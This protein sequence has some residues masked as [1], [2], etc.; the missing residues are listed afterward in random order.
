[1]RFFASLLSFIVLGCGLASAEAQLVIGTYN[2]RTRTLNDQTNDPATN[3]YWDI[4]SEAVMQ[5]IRDGAFDVLALNELND[6]VSIDGKSMMQDMRRAFP[7]PEYD[8]VTA[9]TVPYD[10]NS[11]LHAI[12]YKTAVVE[13]LEQGNF[14]HAPDINRC[15]SGQWGEGNQR[16]MSLWA[17]FR[18]KA[19][20]EIFYVM[21]THLHH[22]GDM[23]KN[24][25]SR[26][27]VDMMRRIAGG[28]PA[29]I[30]GDHN[31]AA[32]RKPFYD[33]HRAFFDDS[34]AVAE[35][36]DG[37]D[38]TSNT[39]ND[40]HVR[41]DYV[42]ARSAKILDYS[43]PKEKYGLDFYPSDHFP[44]RVVA[45]LEAPIETRLRYVSPE[46]ADG[47][48]GSI[49]APFNNIQDAIDASG[50]GDTLFIA[51]GTYAPAPTFKIERSLTLVGGYNDD[52]SAIEGV[53]ALTGD[54]NAQVLNIGK[55][56]A[57]E[58]SNFDISG[59]KT[60]TEPG[61]GIACHGPRLMLEN[62]SVHDNITNGTGAGV[63]A[64][65][66]LVAER[67]SFERNITTGNGGAVFCNDNGSTMPWAHSITECVFRGNKAMHGAAAYLKSTLWLNAH[68][69]TFSDNEASGNGIF[70][71]T[72]ARTAS[73]LTFFNNTFA[74]NR[75]AKG[76][77]IFTTRLQ[78]GDTPASVALANN[79]IVANT[80]T[81]QGDGF[82]GAAVNIGNAVNVYLNN[83]IIAANN[84]AAQQA[85]VYCDVPSGVTSSKY[86]VFSTATSVNHAIQS[87]D[88]RAGSYTQA[89][90]WLAQAFD[91]TATDAKL[92][93]QPTDNGGHTPTIRIVNPVYGTYNL[94]KL[95]SSR[96]V[97]T[98]IKADINGD[99]QVLKA[100][101]TSAVDQRGVERDMK[102]HASFGAYEYDP[103]DGITLPTVSPETDGVDEYFN[104]QGVKIS[105]P[106]LPGIYIHKN[107]SSASKT[108]IK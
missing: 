21:C 11:V 33:L 62:V 89:A 9:L 30:C 13:L 63:Y 71:V 104:L 50:C 34:R 106:S 80:A 69:N 39:W 35:K 82:N 15:L 49:D 29:F 96:F 98:T 60:T 68:A 58:M 94:D 76:A 27:N 95:A 51:K 70:Y 56:A 53:S 19:T 102:G 26:I 18:V 16:R 101:T 105:E 25:G 10:K 81:G 72:G 83:N 48:D 107:G 44:V 37:S 43:C 64:Y 8:F 99:R 66:Q 65:G 87:T 52:F 23:A 3:R 12:L 7:E 91:G 5:T 17:K 45:Q 77:A 1:M 79:T 84:S 32:S 61:A 40:L 31:C 88:Y 78:E 74:N 2:V 4:R 24:E 46:A 55:K 42:W 86:N 59:G 73:Y 90:E 54:E 28:Y 36:T 67:C 93:V 108:I 103:S 92:I 100:T 6:N 14:W 57:V 22:T 38:F 85:D 20:D 47:G 97:E 75:A 41:L